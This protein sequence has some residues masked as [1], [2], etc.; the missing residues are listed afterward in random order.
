VSR[1]GPASQQVKPGV[2]T[3][4]RLFWRAL[5]TLIPVATLLYMFWADWAITLPAKIAISAGA[6][7]WIILAAL[8]I[9]HAFVHQMRTLNT[10]I[11]AIRSEDYSLRGTI[12]RE[13]GDLAELFQQINSLTDELQQT[14]QDSKELRGLLERIITQFNVAVVAYDGNDRIV[15]ANHLTEKL[16][17][18]ESSVMIG[19]P[20]K[21]YQ[22]D[23]IL[24]A[25]NSHLLEYAFPGARGRWQVSRQTYIHHGK[26]GN[27][28]FIADLEQVLSE[29]EIKAWQRLIR[30]VAHEVNNSLTPIMSL[31][32]TLSSILGKQ[33]AKS[34]VLPHQ[35]DLLEGLGVISERA[36]NLKNFISDYARIAHLPDAQKKQFDLLPLIARI[37][38]IYREERIELVTSETAVPIFGD[39]TQIEQV[40]INLIKNAIEANA[41]KAKTVVI[42]VACSESTCKVNISD[43][44]S[45]ISNQ[46][47]LFVPFY[48]T[49]PQGAG[50]GLALARR[51]VAA[52]NG[53]LQ[54][55]NREDGTGA[56][57]TL[58]LPLSLER[59]NKHS[60]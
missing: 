4:S 57:A 12:A 33:A 58:I 40:L 3:E 56:I 30:V 10:L 8:S 46:A 34:D 21:F 50:I 1:S 7:V 32:Q 59:S 39:Q 37:L 20:I 11:E 22:L 25:Q 24:P 54:L 47:N 5:S 13:T 16:L 31:C 26:Q 60:P 45:G 9:R 18:V 49:K 15:L 41:D 38:T 43:Q 52:H 51:I 28:L 42:N 29:Q 17:Q 19:K 35:E 53:D 44:G 6:V 2:A 48:T 36:R 27:L 55:Q 14:R 23:R